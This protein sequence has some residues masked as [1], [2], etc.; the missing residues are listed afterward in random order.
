MALDKEGHLL[1]D[2]ER[3]WKFIIAIQESAADDRL[4]YDH[5]MTNQYVAQK[6]SA[7]KKKEKTADHIIAQYDEGSLTAIQVVKVLANYMK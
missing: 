5:V 6:T 2:Q 3:V 4:K 7:Q 1:K